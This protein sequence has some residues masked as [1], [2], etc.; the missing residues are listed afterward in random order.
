MVTVAVRGLTGVYFQ[1]TNMAYVQITQH[2]FVGEVMP[3][4][5]PHMKL[6]SLMK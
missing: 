6:L 2:A 5:M 3:I 1:Q 4:N